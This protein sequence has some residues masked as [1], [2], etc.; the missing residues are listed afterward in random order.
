MFGTGSAKVP[1]GGFKNLPYGLYKIER[2]RD[3]NKFPNAHTWFLF[4]FRF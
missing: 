1:I 3:N 2:I 4:Q